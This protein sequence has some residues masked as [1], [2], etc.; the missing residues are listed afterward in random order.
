[1]QRR[2]GIYSTVKPY[3]EEHIM[4]CLVRGQFYYKKDCYFVGWWLVDKE[5]L[6][7]IKD[8]CRPSDL[9]SGGIMYIPECVCFSGM[10]EIRR[11]V[12]TKLKK[13][14]HWHRD[15]KG[16]QD[17]DRQKGGQHGK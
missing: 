3:V 1:M 15:K 4:E 11:K 9:H 16:F 13:G 12:R 5:G 7:A 6:E 8:H 14:A 17:F 2:G 10:D